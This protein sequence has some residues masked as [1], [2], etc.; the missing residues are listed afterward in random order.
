MVAISYSDNPN[1]HFPVFLFN[2][3]STFMGYSVL[4]EG[5]K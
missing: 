1:E 5:H 2:G 4:V 3:I